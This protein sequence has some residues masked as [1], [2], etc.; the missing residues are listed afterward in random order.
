[1]PQHNT[2]TQDLVVSRDKTCPAWG[3]LEKPHSTLVNNLTLIGCLVGV[4]PERDLT[5]IPS[6]DKQQQ[7]WMPGEG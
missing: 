1:M 3:P 4:I 7:V 6:N 5:V 2:T